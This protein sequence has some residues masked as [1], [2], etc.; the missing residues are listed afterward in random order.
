M[1]TVPDWSIQ[2]AWWL[3]GICATG[4]V[5]YFLSK[6]STAS[7][8]GSGLGAM[9]F[10]AAAIVL[11]RKKDQLTADANA[12]QRGVATLTGDINLINLNRERIEVIYPS[13]FKVRPN[14]VVDAIQGNINL[15]ILEER[16][17]GFVVRGGS[18]SWVNDRLSIRW[19]AKGLL[20]QP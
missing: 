15:T 13:R 18:A 11:H 14:L 1:R 2:V 8:L 19:T 7:A 4:A 9:I 10:A 12:D 3:S 20:D 16:P 6:N 17:D 5:W